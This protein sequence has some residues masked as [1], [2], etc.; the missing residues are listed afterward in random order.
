MKKILKE[1]YVDQIYYL[2]KMINIFI[3]C[4]LLK[5]YKKNMNY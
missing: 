3:K 5:I 1:N 4:K 2:N